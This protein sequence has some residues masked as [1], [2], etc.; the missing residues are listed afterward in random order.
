M[1]T[2]TMTEERG[3]CCWLSGEC[4]LSTLATLVILL[5]S[6]GFKDQIYANNCQICISTRELF[7]YILLDV[8]TYPRLNSY[9]FSDICSI[10]SF[11][12]RI[13][14]CFR[15]KD[16]ESSTVHPDCLDIMLNHLQNNLITTYHSHHSLPGPRISPS[17]A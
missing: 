16:L 6:P 11:P 13:F 12:H 2:F 15:S 10:C 7:P 17:L 3:F 5:Q 1:F 8:L 9:I 4:Y 14:Q